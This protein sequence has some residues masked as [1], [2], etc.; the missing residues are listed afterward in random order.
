MIGSIVRKVAKLFGYSFEMEYQTFLENPGSRLTLEPG[1]LLSH[2]AECQDDVTFMQ[3]GA[4]DGKRN[5]PIYKHVLK[6]NW[7]GLLVEPDPNLF[8]RLQTNYAGQEQLKFLN[9]AV[10]TGKSAEF[11]FID[12]ASAQNAPSWANGLGSLCKEVVLSHQ[13]LWPEL[14]SLL[15]S[16]TIETIP[17]EALFDTFG[18]SEVDLLLM[19]VEGYEHDIITNIDFRKRDVA[20]VYY[21]HKHL[22]RNKHEAVLRYLT[23]HGYRVGISSIDSIAVKNA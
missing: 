5:D 14:P 22:P 10:G 15:R 19:D 9:T 13:A 12:I 23:N 18:Q 1:W 17:P 6:H 11:Y 20:V 21:E 4:N 3:I 16:R 8:A 7:R 2:L